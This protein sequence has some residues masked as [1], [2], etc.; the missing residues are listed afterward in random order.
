MKITNMIGSFNVKLEIVV[1]EFREQLAG[2]WA[3][4]GLNSRS[5]LFGKIVQKSQIWLYDEPE[6]VGAD[7]FCYYLIENGEK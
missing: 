7:S 4:E 3:H 1:V 5:K 6:F 2:T